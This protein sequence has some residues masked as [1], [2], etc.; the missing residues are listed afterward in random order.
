MVGGGFGSRGDSCVMLREGAEGVAA[1]DLGFGLPQ[2]LGAIAGCTNN[3]G[4]ALMLGGTVPSTTAISCMSPVV[5][6]FSS[7]VV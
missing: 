5:V 4:R 7:T 1:T 6:F 3:D 2:K